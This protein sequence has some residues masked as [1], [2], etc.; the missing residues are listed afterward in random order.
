MLPPGLVPEHTT[1]APSS[2]SDG[3]CTGL[4]PFARLYIC[5]VKLIQGIPIVMSTLWLFIGALNSSSSILSPNWDSS[6]DCLEIRNST[7]TGKLDEWI[8]DLYTF[9]E[10]HVTSTTG[11]QAWGGT[12]GSQRE[13]WSRWLLEERAEHPAICLRKQDKRHG[14]LSVVRK[15]ILI[16]LFMFN[17]SFYSNVLVSIYWCQR[18]I[19]WKCI[20]RNIFQTGSWWSLAYLVFALRLCYDNCGITN[21]YP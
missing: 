16:F 1:S 20:Q 17:Y 7:E 9:M 5:T 19:Q 6:D 4:D 14:A 21:K 11:T 18:T 13:D 8:R 12:T 3:A 10:S 2:T 15:K